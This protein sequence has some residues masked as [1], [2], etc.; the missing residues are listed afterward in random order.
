MGLTLEIQD[1]KPYVHAHTDTIPT[2]RD[3]NFSSHTAQQSTS[4]AVILRNAIS[5][6]VIFKARRVTGIYD[7]NSS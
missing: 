6:W 7:T 5:Q 1:Y 4:Q 2:G 3:C